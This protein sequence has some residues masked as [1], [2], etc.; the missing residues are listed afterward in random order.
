M[1]ANSSNSRQPLPLHVQPLPGDFFKKTDYD[2]YSKLFEAPEFWEKVIGDHVLVF[3]PDSWVCRNAVAKLSK[4]MSYD[5]IGAPWN[6]KVPGCNNSVGNG[7]FSLRSKKAMLQATLAG[8]S[9][10]KVLQP[11]VLNRTMAEDIFFCHE[12]E[13]V[14]ASIPEAHSAVDFAVEERI[15]ARTDDPVGVHRP[16]NYAQDWYLLEEKCPGLRTLHQVHYASQFGPSMNCAS[17]KQDVGKYLQT[18]R[19]DLAEFTKRSLAS[20]LWKVSLILWS[21][22][23]CGVCTHL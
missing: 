14:N 23:A 10:P 17:A 13:L 22:M 15:S 11:H 4:W 1:T 12:L 5:Y 2:S 21:L 6:H 19:V 3:N 16:W 7:G 9:R 8:T 20:R 18:Y